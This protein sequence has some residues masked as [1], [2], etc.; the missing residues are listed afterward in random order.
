MLPY[1]FFYILTHVQNNEKTQIRITMSYRIVRKTS[2]DKPQAKFQSQS[3]SNQTGKGNLASG[4][5]LKYHGP[6][7]PPHSPFSVDFMQI[8]GSADILY[9][10]S[11][12]VVDK[13]Y[14][15]SV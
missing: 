6:P 15:V 12:N 13:N 1:P 5:S 4:L 11:S 7:T 2:I 10:I 9:V 14:S 3:Q 8:F